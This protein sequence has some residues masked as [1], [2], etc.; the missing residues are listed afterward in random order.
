MVDYSLFTFFQHLFLNRVILNLNPPPA[1]YKKQAY[2]HKTISLSTLQNACC[3][4]LISSDSPTMP[5]ASTG[6]APT[7]LVRQTH[8]SW[9]PK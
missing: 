1:P 4:L 2:R 6:T 8:K 3:K 5:R 7:Q 9:Q